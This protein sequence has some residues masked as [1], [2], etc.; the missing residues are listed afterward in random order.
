MRKYEEMVPE[1][2][3]LS[4]FDGRQKWLYSLTIEELREFRRG[5]NNTQDWIKSWQSYIDSVISHK[6]TEI[7]EGKL[8]DLGL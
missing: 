7:R 2:S 3:A 1:F 6:I 8:D 5:L 4:G